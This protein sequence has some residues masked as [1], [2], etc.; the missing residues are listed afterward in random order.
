M[1]G[2]V[3]SIAKHPIRM[4]F[5]AGITVTVNTDDPLIF[6][7]TISEEFLGLHDVG[8]FTASELDQIRLNGLV[9]DRSRPLPRDARESNV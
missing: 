8:V 3:E 6:G 9:D 1:L 4:L 5:D 2:R 7:K